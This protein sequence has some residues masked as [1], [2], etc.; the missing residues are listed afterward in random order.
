M[1]QTGDHELGEAGRRLQ[2]ARLSQGWR[3]RCSDSMRIESV[4]GLTARAAETLIR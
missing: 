2:L 3:R 1:S 4:A